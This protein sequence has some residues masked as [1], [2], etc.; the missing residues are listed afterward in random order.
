M[1]GYAVRLFENGWPRKD[2]KT[3][4]F[5]YESYASKFSMMTIVKCFFRW[6]RVILSLPCVC[7]VTRFGMMRKH[8][9][10][11]CHKIKVYIS[12]FSHSIKLNWYVLHMHIYQAI[13]YTKMRDHMVWSKWI[14]FKITIGQP[15]L[16]ILFIRN[17][18]DQASAG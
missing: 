12:L 3:L 8:L 13:F 6:R 10:V 4:V 2:K 11:R 5:S 17:E 18:S 7:E 14:C 16:V 9:G 15:K 1:K